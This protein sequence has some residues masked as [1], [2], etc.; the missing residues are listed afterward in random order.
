MKTAMKPF[1]PE[2][3]CDAELVAKLKELRQDGTYPAQSFARQVIRQAMR[4]HEVGKVEAGLLVRWT[5]S[6]TR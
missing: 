2:L 1:N 4:F 6:W 5:Y 3:I